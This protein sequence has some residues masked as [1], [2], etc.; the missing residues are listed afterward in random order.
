M[1]VIDK[2]DTFVPTEIAVYGELPRN[3]KDTT[4]VALREYRGGEQ[5]LDI[6]IFEPRL[7]KGVLQQSARAGVTFKPSQLPDLIRALQ[8]A[9]EDAT[10]RGLI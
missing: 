2:S 10:M 8:K 9:H 5:K 6:R 7:S 1:S 4:V 3:R